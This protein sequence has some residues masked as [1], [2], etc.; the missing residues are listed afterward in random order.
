MSETSTVVRE[1]G[2]PID[3]PTAP[4]AISPELPKTRTDADRKAMLAQSVANE[5]RKDWR[6]QSQ[7]DFQAVMEKGKRTSHGLHVFLSIVTLGIWIP[8][9]IAVWYLNRDQNEVI[10]VDGYGNVNIAT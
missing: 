2:P 10:N 8:V 9:W 3:D 1:A 5:V 4:E 7:T 6:V